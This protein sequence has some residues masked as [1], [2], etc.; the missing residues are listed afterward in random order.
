MRCLLHWSPKFYNN[1]FIFVSLTTLW[2]NTE[3]WLVGLLSLSVQTFQQLILIYRRSNFVC[4]YW[5]CTSIYRQFSYTFRSLLI[6]NSFAI[7][8]VMN[9]EKGKMETKISNLTTKM[10]QMSAT[11]EEEQQLNRSLTQNQVRWWLLERKK[12]QLAVY[13]SSH[14]VFLFVGLTFGTF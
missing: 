3:F 1:V 4:H 11:L 5:E 6:F 2:T 9:K 14:N 8:D 13:Y 7:S 10:S 12:G